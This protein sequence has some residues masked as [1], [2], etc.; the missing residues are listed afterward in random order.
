MVKHEMFW[1]ILWFKHQEQEWERRGKKSQKPGQ[2]AYAF[3][4]MNVWARFR[5]SAEESFE[6]YMTAVK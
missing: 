3:K 5:K 1:T 6:Q 4:Q 2:Q